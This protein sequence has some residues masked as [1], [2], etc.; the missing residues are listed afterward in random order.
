MQYLVIALFSFVLGKIQNG[1]RLILILNNNIN[2]NILIFISWKSIITLLSFDHVVT[3]LYSTLITLYKVTARESGV[4][5]H[6]VQ[7]R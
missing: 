5:G 1:S 6:T 4:K 7:H 2:N 3:F